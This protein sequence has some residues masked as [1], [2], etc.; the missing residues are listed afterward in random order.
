MR[1]S[2]VVAGMILFSSL[3][4]SAI[5][6]NFL[7]Y[8]PSNYFKESDWLMM[9]QAGREALESADNG[10]TRNWS[11]PETGAAGRVKPLNTYEAKGMTCRYTEIF[12]SV[13]HA[14][15]TSR[16]D[17]CRQADGDWKIAPTR[18]PVKALGESAE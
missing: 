18:G 9:R 16:F 1:V 14:Q 6:W 13:K 17:F 8:S 10:E 15:G 11:N 5:N 4:V 7:E 2:L 3:P 12:N